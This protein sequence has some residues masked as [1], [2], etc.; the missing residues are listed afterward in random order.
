MVVRAMLELEAHRNL[1][2]ETVE[3]ILTTQGSIQ[4]SRKCLSD[5]AT[6]FQARQDGLM[7]VVERG[8]GDSAYSDMITPIV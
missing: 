6:K 7:A 8:R 1:Y 3:L 5:L 2:Q 4:E